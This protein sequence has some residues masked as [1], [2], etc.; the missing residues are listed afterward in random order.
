M[1]VSHSFK[2]DYIMSLMLNQ[3]DVEKGL[4]HIDSKSS[5]GYCG[6][7]TSIFS[8]NANKL[9]L[10]I[11]SLFNLCLESGK[12]SSNRKTALVRPYYKIKGSKHDPDRQ[13]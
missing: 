12:I 13:I 5:P 11:T 10:L 2:I 6:I 4:T 7:L 3:D 8:A 1:F 9:S